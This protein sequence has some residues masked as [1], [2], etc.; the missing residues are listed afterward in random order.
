MDFMQA[1]G[2]CFCECLCD[3]IPGD[4]TVKRCRKSVDRTLKFLDECI[5]IKE[6][7]KVLLGLLLKI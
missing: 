5:K 3:T 1:V 4:E 6:H 2:I 7:R